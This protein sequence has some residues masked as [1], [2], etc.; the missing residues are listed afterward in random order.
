MGA[1]ELSAA[2]R[3]ELLRVHDAWV[4]VVKKASQLSAQEC[5]VLDGIRTVD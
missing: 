4:S 2:S 5:A 1:F 3:K